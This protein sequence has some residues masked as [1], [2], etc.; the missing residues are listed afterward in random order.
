[1]PIVG[2]LNAHVPCH[3]AHT[4]GWAWFLYGLLSLLWTHLLKL[5]NKEG[6]TKCKLTRESPPHLYDEVD[7]NNL[8]WRPKDWTMGKTRGSKV[9]Y[10]SEVLYLSPILSLAPRLAPLV[11]MRTWCIWKGM[12]RVKYDKYYNQQAYI[13][14]FCF[15][16]PRLYQQI[17]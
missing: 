1:M 2:S 17:N 7:D 9:V 3:V 8:R 4:H 6:I 13:V 12:R 10:M 5:Y 11:P 15:F 14:F 16:I